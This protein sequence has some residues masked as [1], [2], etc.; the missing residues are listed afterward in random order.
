M[1]HFDPKTALRDRGFSARQLAKPAVSQKRDHVTRRTVPYGSLT[2]LLSEPN[3][4]HVQ[5]SSALSGERIS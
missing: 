4:T 3:C 1:A 2:V 5:K